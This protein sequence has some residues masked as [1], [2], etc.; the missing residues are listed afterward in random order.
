MSNQIVKVCVRVPVKRKSELLELANRWR[1]E[2]HEIHA[3]AP[4]W[5]A[6]AIHEIAKTHYGGL[7][8]MYE[9]HRWPERGSNMMRQ[10][11]KRIK[12]TYGDVATFI[13]RHKI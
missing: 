8:E 5:D 12:E 11:Q 1:R 2:D 7:L 4:G 13:A 9:H 10:V 6:I 3:R